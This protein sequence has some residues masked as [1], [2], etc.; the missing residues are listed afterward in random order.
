MQESKPLIMKNIFTLLLFLHIVTCVFSSEVNWNIRYEGSDI[1]TSL[2]FDVTDGDFG[3]LLPLGTNFTDAGVSG[4]FRL[5][6]QE[7]VSLPLGTNNLIGIQLKITPYNNSDVLQTGLAVTTDL[8][9][10][11]FVDEGGVHIDASDYRFAGFY[12]Y[13]VEVLAMTVGGS[14]VSSFSEYIYLETGI[15]AERY[16]ALNTTFEPT[17]GVQYV[18]YTSTGSLNI[19]EIKV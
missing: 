14:P 16:Y 4:Y 18:S 13:K 9:V 19:L 8:E 7:R 5:G 15:R 6:I 17:F 10:D 12:K 2:V 11:Y 1:N 3:S